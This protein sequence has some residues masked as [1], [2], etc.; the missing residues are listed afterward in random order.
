MPPKKVMVL[1][2]SVLAEFL[3]H[4][5]RDRE[6]ILP[7]E[8]DNSVQYVVYKQGISPD[9]SA[10]PVFP[11][12]DIF[13][14]MREVIMTWEDK[15]ITVPKIQVKPKVLFGLR[16]C[17]LNAIRR[18]DIVFSGEFSDPYYLKH[19]ESTL[20]VGYHC[21]EAPTENCFCG[22]MQLQDF[23]DIMLYDRGE[24]FKVEL[25][26]EKG[27]KL[28][29]EFKEFFSPSDEPITKED[30][31]IQGL[32]TLDFSKIEGSKSDSGWDKLVSLCLSCG[33]CTAI[34]PTCYCYEIHDEIDPCNLEKG[35]RVR[36]W[37]SCQLQSFTRVAGDQVFRKERKDRFL[38]RIFHQLLYF[39]EKN[40]EPLCVG[41][42]RCISSCPNKINFM[43]V[44]NFI[45]KET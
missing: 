28:V 24:H 31:K 22:S 43:E 2:K 17:D 3:E 1:K 20:L 30:R 27:D 12:K 32:C 33:A 23:F 4:L 19:R 44:L 38:Q 11:I 26:S 14:D 36:T 35:E 29:K 10:L 39:E 18:Q 41:C 7:A 6:I 37:S 40:G 25:S 21:D 42:G 9:F 45:S 13:F 5:N 34:C 15:K 8:K 16:R